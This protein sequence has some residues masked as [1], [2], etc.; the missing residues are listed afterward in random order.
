MRWVALVAERKKGQT[1]QDAQA[2]LSDG[3]K[4]GP[5][6]RSRGVSQTA[7]EL[8]MPRDDVRRAMKVGNLSSE[9]KE[10]ARK[11]GLADNRDALLAA[12]KA[13]RR[14]GRRRLKIGKNAVWT[15]N[16]ASPI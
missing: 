5:Q 7:R 1:A 16:G 10:A 9:A 15:L 4:A 14:P 13:R 2:V 12:P 6:H 11:H 8:N 3:R